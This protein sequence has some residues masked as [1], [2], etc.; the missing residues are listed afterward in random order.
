MNRYWH[1]WR[2]EIKHG[3]PFPKWYGLAYR[4]FE[5]D[6]A[7]FYPLPFNKLV[8]WWY[9]FTFW[10]RCQNKSKRERMER[11]WIEVG[12]ELERKRMERLTEIEFKRVMGDR[13]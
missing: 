4:C 11:H 8:Y 1:G 2:L 3:E 10:L 9:E 6:V 12:V 7:V 13:P 5:R